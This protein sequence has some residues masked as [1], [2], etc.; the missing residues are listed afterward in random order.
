ME[1]AQGKI[2]EMIDHQNDKVESEENSKYEAFN[3]DGSPKTHE[4]V[5]DKLDNSKK[6]LEDKIANI[7]DENK[8]E[9]EKK[10]IIVKSVPST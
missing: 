9:D 2:G 5:M 8:T 3:N 6:D 7:K 10:G 1:D 4:E